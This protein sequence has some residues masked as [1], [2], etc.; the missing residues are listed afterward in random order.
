MDSFEPR[1]LRAEVVSVEALSPR[2]AGFTLLTL[3]PDPIEWTAGQYLEL[4]LPGDERRM[5]YSIASAMD[6]NRPG[7]LEL[8]VARG[9]G[10]GMFDDVAVGANVEVLGP[11]GGF[12]RR[13]DGVAPEVFIG[14]GTG[15]APLRAMLQEALARGG[16]APLMVLFGAR[17][18]PEILWRKELEAL[19][20][21]EP[22]FRYETTLSESQNGWAG[23]RGRVQDH[24]T[25]LVAPLSDA[26][27]YVCG[28]SPMVSDCVQDL[29]GPLGFAADRVFTETH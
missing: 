17:A 27:I 20:A 19:A 13:G 18:E 8:A 26:L 11:K 4:G 21:R 23:R 6:P 22:R 3:G 10:S 14:A 29:T 16:T 2:V 24:L 25:E 5:P 15:L 7:R 12:V 1:L 28:P 9:S